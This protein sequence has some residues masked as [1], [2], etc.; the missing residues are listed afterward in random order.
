LFTTAYFADAAMGT[1]PLYYQWYF[2]PTNR[3][4]TFA[5]LAGQTG[6]ALSRTLSDYTYA[7][8]YYVVASNAVNGGSIAYSPTNS[9]T[10][11]A[12]VA[13]TLGQLYNLMISLTNQ[14]AANAKGTIN[15]NT[16]NVTVSGY[17]TTYGGFGS[18]YS[19]FFIQD[20]SGHG[21]QVY[22]GGHG[23]TNTPPVGTYVTVTGP[24][25]IYH[26]ALEIEPTSVSAIVPGAAPVV[27]LTPV[28]ANADFN[29]LATNGLSPNSLVTGDS[30]VTFTNVYIYANK[31]GGALSAGQ[32][33]YAD[34]Y[35]TAYFTVGPYDPVTNA[36]MI[37][38][39]QFCYNYPN[40]FP[41]TT[42]TGTYSPF[43][44]QTI[45][46]YCYQ[47]TGV[48]NPY[49]GSPEIEPS[50]LADYVVTPPPPFTAGVTQ[51]NE[52]IPTITWPAQAGSTYSVY[53]ATNVLGPWTQAA[54]GLAYYP[55]NGAFTDTNNAAAKFYRVSTP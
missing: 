23:N 19:E 12:P 53:S 38:I 46:T 42:A 2:A 28:L 4:T 35:T 44:N 49:G 27:S 31:S 16:N 13:G 24:I 3:P 18:S 48:Y 17:V 22:L 7:G 39:Y 26:S 34:G 55:P 15:V 51:A 25:V 1:G 40:T 14:I 21:I 9:L 47:L 5:L 36:N 29:N 37:E 54:S 52:G 6:P 8:Q 45:P 41:A 11:I 33:F 32:K 10:E 20:A 43:Y 50:R 30:L